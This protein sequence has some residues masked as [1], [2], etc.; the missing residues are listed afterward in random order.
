MDIRSLSTS[1]PKQATDAA[2]TDA[3][4]TD[5]AR[6][7]D[8]ASSAGGARSVPPPKRRWLTRVLLPAAILLLTGGLLAYAARESIFPATEVRIVRVVAK[9]GGGGG[10]G[11]APAAPATVSV[12][13]PGWVEPD[14]YPVFVTALTDGVIETVDVLE[15]A[16]VE[17]GQTVA[18]LVDDDAQLAAARAKAELAR[19]KAHLAAAQADWDNPVAR[20]RA[21]AVTR[22]QLAETR[23]ELAQLDATITQQQAKLSELKAAYDRVAQLGPNAA[24]KLEVEQAQ[25][26]VEAQRALVEATRKQMP[27]IEAKVDRYKAELKAAEDDLR[28]RVAERKA[29]DEAKAAADEA[30]AALD[31]ANLRLKRMT[32]ISPV[33]GV[34][35]RRL[36]APGAKVMLGS[37]MEHSAH[38]VHV[39]D[40]K[41]LQVRVDVPLAD[42]AKVGVGQKAQV[43]VDVLPDQEFAGIVTR[44]VHQAD[45][46]KNTIE[47]KVAIKNPSPL[48]KP[49][50][51]ARVKFLATPREDG[52]TPAAG[53]SSLVVYAP[54]KAVRGEGDNAHVWLVTPGES[55]LKK[56]AV[57]L[58]GERGDGWV[59]VLEGLQPGD[60]L[61]AEPTDELEQGQRVSVV[62]E[63]S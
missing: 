2:R 50:M 27:V 51:L 38:I 1:A 44:F 32:I 5:A 11:A 7:D 24:S 16:V 4:H 48:L 56:R 14:P 12:K 3:A 37:D 6:A 29:L 47:V 22:A 60:A 10:D 18:T 54:R 15:G 46:S 34:V 57:T 19:R 42:A 62:E 55:R 8:S 31:E 41:K 28:L 40:P 36:V 30:Q 52:A 21:V 23:A 39:Y 45:I 63:E 58:G 43:I 25:F 59:A 33:A 9:E 35:M 49:D 13:A 17:K 61:V 20:D 53:A 26:Q